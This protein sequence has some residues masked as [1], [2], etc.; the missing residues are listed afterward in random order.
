L[1][2]AVPFPGPPSGALLDLAELAHPGDKGM[3]VKIYTALHNNV[4]NYFALQKGLQIGAN[5]LKDL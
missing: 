3:M 1:I 5:L 2:I 4:K